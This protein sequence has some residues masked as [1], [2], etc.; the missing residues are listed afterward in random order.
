MLPNNT[1]GGKSR[2]LAYQIIVD[3]QKEK[4]MTNTIITN[5]SYALVFVALVI[6]NHFGF[7]NNEIALPSITFVLG[8]WLGLQIIPPKLASQVTIT[9]VVPLP[10]TPTTIVAHVEPLAHTPDAPKEA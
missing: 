9:P 10:T 4:T 5:V 8:N 6:G 1:S 3:G 7:I 2:P